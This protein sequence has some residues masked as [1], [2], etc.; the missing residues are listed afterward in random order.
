MACIL[1]KYVLS[2]IYLHVLFIVSTLNTKVKHLVTQVT[3]FPELAWISNKYRCTLLKL[4]TKENHLRKRPPIIEVF[5]ATENIHNF[6]LD[7]W[8]AK[9]KALECFLFQDKFKEPKQ[10]KLNELCVD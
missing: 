7:L 9:E 5:A 1:V 6:I 2:K 3:S 8:K 4:S 10:N